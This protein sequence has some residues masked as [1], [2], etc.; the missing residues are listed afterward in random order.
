[1]LCF[2]VDTLTALVLAWLAKRHKGMGG[3]ARIASAA[4]GTFAHGLAHLGLWAGSRDGSSPDLAA[5]YLQEMSPASRLGS[6]AQTFAFFFLLLRSAP[7]VGNYHAAGWSALHGAVLSLFVPAKLGFTYVQTALLWVVAAYDMRQ[8]AKDKDFYYDLGA[9]VVGVP[10]GLVAW[11]EALACDSFF[12]SMGGHVW[13]NGIIPRS[14][15]LL[16]TFDLL[17][18]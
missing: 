8:P 4:A 17:T 6:W 5:G 2:Y 14:L 15:S 10:V 16:L 7:G 12:K 1:M 13:C 18:H 11:V 9:V 3:H